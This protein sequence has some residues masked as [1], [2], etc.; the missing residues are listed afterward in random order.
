MPCSD[1]ELDDR[2][3]ADARTLIAC[4]YDELRRVAHGQMAR[5]AEPGTLQT[6]ALV[7]EAWLRLEREGRATWESRAQFFIAA[8]T[9]MRRILVERARERGRLKRGGAYERVAW[10]ESLIEGASVAAGAGA[11]AQGLLALD[12]ALD[13]LRSFDARLVQIVELRV[14]AGMTEAE[15]AAVLGKSQ[16]SVRRDYRAARLWLWRR[17]EGEEDA[18]LHAG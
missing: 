15:T 7:H 12:R 9:A 4:V 1:P 5:E 2:P 8:A 14:F 10:H 17:V 13:A 11:D 3:D 16:R 6:T 18:P